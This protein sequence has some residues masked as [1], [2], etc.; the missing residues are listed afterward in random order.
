M[1]EWM[2]EMREGGSSPLG[3]TCFVVQ[4]ALAPGG[5]NYPALYLVDTMKAH[6]WHFTRHKVRSFH[7]LKRLGQ[8][9]SGI[10]ELLV[11]AHNFTH[12]HRPRML[13]WIAGAQGYI[14]YAYIEDYQKGDTLQTPTPHTSPQNQPSEIGL[15]RFD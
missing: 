12:T 11:I 8:T 3:G 13:A 4:A 9:L 2:L 7:A 14:Y 1:G 6:H 5:G 10:V 15:P